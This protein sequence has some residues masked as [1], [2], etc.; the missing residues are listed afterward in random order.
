MVGVTSL[1]LAMHPIQAA[2]D[3]IRNRPIIIPHLEEGECKFP[4]FDC[5]HVTLILLEVPSRGLL[6][7]SDLKY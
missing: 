6:C 7:S 5:A 3:E 4:H 1:K 2:M